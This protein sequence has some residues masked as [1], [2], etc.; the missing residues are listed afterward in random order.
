[1]NA[2]PDTLVGMEGQPLDALEGTLNGRSMEAEPLGQL[3]ERR[4]GS[5]APS[6]GDEPDRVRLLGQPAVDLE[7]VDRGDLP[8]GRTHRTLEIRRLRVEDAVQV[9]SQRPRHLASL[10]LEEGAAGTDPPEEQADRVAVLPCH[11]TPATA[12]PPRRRQAHGRETS[13]ERFGLVDPDDEL[14]VRPAAGEAQ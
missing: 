3:A 11:D 9:A 6:V 10:D 4:L 5:R 12:D 1:M 2:P 7:L 14:E 8:P 13:G